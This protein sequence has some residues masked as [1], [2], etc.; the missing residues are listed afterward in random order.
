MSG[1]HQVDRSYFD[2]KCYNG[3]EMKI[4]NDREV[5]I[6]KSY[7]GFTYGKILY[8]FANLLH[9]NYTKTKFVTTHFMGFYLCDNI[10]IQ[11]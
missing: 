7:N 6:L 2:K 11:R 3:F 1:T 8:M 9:E 10:Y 4:H 5:I